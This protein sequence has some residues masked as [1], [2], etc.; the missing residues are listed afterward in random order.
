MGKKS[1][2]LRFINDV[3]EIVQ[4]LNDTQIEV[5]MYTADQLNIN[6]CKGCINCFLKGKCVLDNMDDMKRIKE[7]I[8][9]SDIVVFASPVYA[10]HV[11]GDMKVF[12]DRISY[13][14]HLVR[15]SGKVGIAVATSGGN[16]LDLTTNYLYKIMSYMGIKV[17]GKFGV[18][19]YEINDGY[20]GTVEDC[21]KLI[22]EYLH[23]KPIESDEVLES[24]FRVTKNM[25]ELAR[26]YKTAEYEYWDEMGLLK[27][28]SFEEVLK[29]VK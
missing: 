27:C 19:A 17:V 3:L 7:E 12:I 13:W 15:L 1:R 11:S 24:V 4:N 22:L 25:I 23:D 14:A 9:S 10:H 28:N 6:N 18:E 26:E 5:N 8:L 20:N 21:A 16:G 29:M 2:T